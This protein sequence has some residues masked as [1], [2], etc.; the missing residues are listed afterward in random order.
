[1]GV[2]HRSGAGALVLRQAPESSTTPAVAPLTAVP[3]MELLERERCLLDLGEWLDTAVDRGGLVALVG[4]EAGIGKTTLLQEFSRQQRK[5][6]KTLWGACDAL[7]TP[8]PLAPLHDIARQ[9][10]KA[11]LAAITAGERDAI[12]T[13]TLDELE[14]GPPAL[15]VLED[16]HWA[17]E[18][19]LDLVKFLGRRI[20]RTR[21]LLAV[22]YRD[23]EVGPRHPLRLVIG[24]LPRTN[25]RRLHLP[26]LSESAVAKLAWKAGRSA[27]GLH[28]ATGGN[29][30]FLTE[31]LA[32]GA[33]AVP[34][35]VRDAVLARALRL[36]PEAREIAELVSIVPGKTEAW[37]LEQTVK[38][39]EAGI[40]ECLGIGMIRGA[41][42]SLAFRHE[43][44]RRALE[45]TIPPPRQQELH[46]KVL[47]ILGQKTGVPPA[48][49]AHHADRTGNAE[50]ALRFARAAGTQ[51]AAVGAHREAASHYQLALQ[52]AARLPDS[53]RAQ[54][55]EQLA[56]ECYLTDQIEPAIEAQHAALDIRRAAGEKLK[57]GDT[58]RWLSRLSWFAGRRAEAD[59]YAAAAVAVLDPLPPGPELA[60]AYS[61]R[62]QLDMLAD[63]FESSITWAERTIRIA[64]P[65]GYDEILSHALNNLGTSR[66]H[67]NRAEGQA[68]L[69]RSLEIALTRG[70]QEHAARA[71]TNLSS[72]LVKQH[73]YTPA[74]RYLN[75]GLAYCEKHD[76]DSWRLY[77]LAWRARARFELGHW[78]QA[79]EDA[80]AVLR[81]PRTAAI[82]RIPALTVLGHLRIRRGDTDASSPID[83]A[84]ELA[85]RAQEV[86]RLAPLA[87]ALADSAWLAGDYQRIAQEIGPAW[88]MAQK[89]CDPWTKGELAV[90]LSRAGALASVPAD[91]A[92]PYRLELSGD[93]QSAAKTW[94]VLGC[95]YEY[96][97]V[98]AWN[99]GEAEQLQALAMMEQLG[100]TAASNALRRDMRARGVRRV[101]R[102]S[103]TST[104][105]HPHGLTR[106]EAEVLEL[107]SEGL[108]NSTIATRLFV[109]TKTVDHH[110]SAILMKLG[111]PSR[112]EAV[113]MARR[114]RNEAVDD[115]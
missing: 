93:W 44:A 61:N 3:E 81:H 87:C 55:Y 19:T 72:V 71:Y 63:A 1:M 25:V 46:S 76:L 73:E 74:L 43:L 92:E 57:E 59:R 41:D 39:D 12:F 97:S 15:V 9:T 60:M 115:S 84:Q 54:L 31:V 111:V 69:E 79:G 108:R 105:S 52:H 113:A 64:E 35:T 22:T 47:A 24:E 96:A 13:A 29:P 67:S 106:R 99:G 6:P 14:R 83:E 23:D 34:V 10:Q 7:F 86:Q 91:V 65:A 51:A 42:N 103:R 104:R 33:E 114:S 98:L 8:R 18:A 66:L 53:D 85:T 90:W 17:D 89:G 45:D 100:A 30:F 110:V 27:E 28:S 94:Q 102:G 80:E 38:P 95:P 82:S 56:Y 49:L 62:A 88:A 112:A 48:R 68:D 21:S 70:Y 107:L 40:E 36:P 5:V 26:A 50:D 11:L 20:Q 75:D 77:M 4:G 2:A 32:T 78:H 58:L 109:S 16:L 101:P 37:L